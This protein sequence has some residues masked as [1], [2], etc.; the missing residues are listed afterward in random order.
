MKYLILFLGLSLTVTAIA[1]G[2]LSGGPARRVQAATCPQGA[3]TIQHIVIMV[4]E[5]RTFDNLFGTYPG[6]DGATTY[7]DS[8]G[9]VKPLRHQ[10]DRLLYDIN[11]SAASAQ[12]AYDNGK[13]DRFSEIPGAHQAGEDMADSQLYQS[14]IP[15]YW[16][17]ARHF[18]LADRFFTTAMGPSFPNHLDMITVQSNAND[19]P[20]P[21]AGYFGCDSPSG[22]T[23]DQL[24]QSGERTLSFPCYD[25]RTIADSLD[26]AGLSWKYFGKPY[27]LHTP[28]GYL[29]S[30]FAAIKH[31]RNGPD[32]R[33]NVVDFTQFAREARKGTLPAVSWLVQPVENSDHPG[34]SICQGENWTV[35]AMNAIMGNRRAWAHTAVVVTWDDFGGLYD[36]VAPPHGPNP[37]VGYGFRVPALM[38]SPYARAGFVDHTQYDFT[39]I[40]T[41][42]EHVFGLSPLGTRDARANSL[43]NSFDFSQKPLPPLPLKTR[44]CHTSNQNLAFQLPRT[45]LALAA[46]T[47]SPQLTID[48]SDQSRGSLLLSRHTVLASA[49]GHPISAADLSPADRLQVSALAVPKQVNTY[50]AVSVR[51]SDLRWGRWSLGIVDSA[52]THVTLRV[53]AAG[54]TGTLDL[55]VPNA[56]VIRDVHGHATSF[57]R[58]PSQLLRV[59]GLYNGRTRALLPSGHIS[60]LGPALR[61]TAQAHSTR[62]G[63]FLSVSAVGTGGTAIEVHAGFGVHGETTLRAAFD[64]TGEYAG[65]VPVPLAATLDRSVVNPVVVTSAVLGLPVRASASYLLK[66]IH[67][68]VSVT[69]S[70]ARPGQSETISVRSPVV[71]AV[72]VGIRWSR[73]QRWTRT[74]SVDAAG[75]GS[76][77]FRLPSYA[78]NHRPVDVR[79]QVSVGGHVQSARTTFQVASRKH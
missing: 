38:I 23:V 56:A 54:K 30:A 17:Y 46:K 16:T 57:N 60:V 1:G 72:T 27:Q 33:R 67:L 68:H 8:S 79:A 22:T 63:R 42:I 43:F 34:A 15:N 39:S 2:T 35:N 45:T 9:K 19:N 55:V 69:L 40:Q 58:L 64:R 41:F 66:P 76:Y 13:M 49:D 61:V 52:A 53:R 14:D 37:Y 51:D 71:G 44:T 6:A 50:Q 20:Q 3:C 31:I 47:A 77:R 11:H 75:I 28:G 29:W 62:Q 59:S 24:E 65:T 10:P 74:I 78:S 4:K 73:H 36:H 25:Y 12:L 32:W 70:Q 48:F 18:S 26:T 7:T 5:N 21:S